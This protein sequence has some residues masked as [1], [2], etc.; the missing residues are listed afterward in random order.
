MT[1]AARRCVP[2]F[3][4]YPFLTGVFHFLFLVVLFLLQVGFDDLS[5]EMPALHDL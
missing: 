3:L 1:G 2:L 4:V 5:L